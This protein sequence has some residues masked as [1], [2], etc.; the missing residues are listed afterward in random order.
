MAL[1]LD[2]FYDRRRLKRRL[3]LWRT[4]AIVAAVVAAVVVLAAA[5]GWKG[6]GLGPH[7]ARLEV[8]GVITDDQDRLKQLEKLADDSSVKALLV[9]ID[10]PGGTVVGGEDL[11]HAVRA[12]AAKKPV[13]TVMSTMAASAGYMVAI[14]ADR[15][16]AREGTLTGSIGVLLQSAEVTGLLQKLGISAE[17]IKS[18][19]LK[20]APSPLEPLTPEARQATQAVVDDIY[21]MFLRL[22]QERRGLDDARLREVGDGR[23]FTGRQA[24]TLGLV[25]SLGGEAEAR[26]WLASER[27]VSAILPVRAVKKDGEMSWLGEMTRAAAGKMLMLETLT[28]DGLVAV[29]QPGLRS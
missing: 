3:F 27:N 1:D 17:A 16:I 18:A 19:P 6:G 23:V 11:Y 21:R 12:V 9:V 24:V 20:A 13:V 22:V 8:K 10:S 14:G 5:S 28:L 15:I 29:W 2:A 4:L 26:A 25:D 7:V